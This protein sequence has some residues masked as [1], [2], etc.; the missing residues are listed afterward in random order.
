MRALLGETVF[1]VDDETMEAVVLARLRARGQTALAEVTSGG[2]AAMRLSALDPRG[3]IFRG[4]IV[5][6]AG[7]ARAA[8][9]DVPAEAGTPA[10]AVALA[11]AARRVFGADIGLATTGQHDRG[12][13]GASAQTIWSRPAHRDRG[14]TGAS[15]ATANACASSP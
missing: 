8:L 4:G 5:P 12:E 2:I 13:D 11:E 14:R 1:G 9:L 6:T 7:A 3:E 15:R 10:A